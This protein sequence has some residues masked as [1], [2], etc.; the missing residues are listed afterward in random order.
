MF[1]IFYRSRGVV[2]ALSGAAIVTAAMLG[3]P[4][5]DAKLGT[6]VY[7]AATPGCDGTQNPFLGS[8]STGGKTV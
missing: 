4:T 7:K 3:L 2:A 5:I 8:A 1:D 6:L